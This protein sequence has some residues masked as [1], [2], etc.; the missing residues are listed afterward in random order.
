MS[1]YEPKH[2]SVQQPKT[3][4]PMTGDKS[5]TIKLRGCEAA[6]D[7]RPPQEVRLARPL[8]SLDFETQMH[9]PV[10]RLPLWLSWLPKKDHGGQEGRQGRY[11]IETITKHGLWMLPTYVHS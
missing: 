4:G 7:A 3:R 1:A 11:K 2:H 5:T 8:S 9:W 10:M 6:R